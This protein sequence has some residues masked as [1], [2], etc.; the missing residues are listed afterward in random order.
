MEPSIWRYAAIVI[1]VSHWRA[2]CDGQP[3]RM[4][5]DEL[6]LVKDACAWKVCDCGGGATSEKKEPTRTSLSGD[7]LIFD[8][9]TPWKY[10]LHDL[11]LTLQVI[12]TP[13]EPGGQMFGGCLCDKEQDGHLLRHLYMR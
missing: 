7:L 12:N 11:R 10:S 13:F 1:S 5:P 8:M 4:R 9:S 3:W 6:C 2:D